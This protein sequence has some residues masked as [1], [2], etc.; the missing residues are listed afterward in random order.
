LDG[1]HGEVLPEYLGILAPL[2]DVL[3]SDLG[4]LPLTSVQLER[5]MDVRHL[6][7]QSG[8]AR[9]TCGEENYKN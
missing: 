4:P 5:L 6:V 1:G 9:A 3:D 7:Q 8:L 2:G